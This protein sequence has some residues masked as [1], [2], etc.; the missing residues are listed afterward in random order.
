MLHSKVITLTSKGMSKLLMPMINAAEFLNSKGWAAGIY[1]NIS[2]VVEDPIEI[3][4]LEPILFE[5]GLF[6]PQLEG[7]T[8]LFTRSGSHLEE[9][10][11]DP[12]Q[13]L[14]LYL[15]TKGGGTLSLLWGE[16][17]PTSEWLSH[18]LIYAHAGGKVK[19]VIHAHMDEVER[20]KAEIGD[21]ASELPDW[22]GW[23]PDLP[24][25]SLDL[26]QATVQEMHRY[27]IMLWHGHGI[28]A[29]GKDLEDSLSRME[30]FSE[31]ARSKMNREDL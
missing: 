28:I 20:L 27:D 13:N 1:G 5:S 30:R 26:A 7:R 23:V 21:L 3:W 12:E 22:I 11:S 8:I 25:G 9:I 6:L 16:G 2:M 19:A 24:P 17:A 4:D 31:W 29:P 18:L 15:C 10:S 14:G